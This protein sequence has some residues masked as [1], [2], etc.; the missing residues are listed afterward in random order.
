MATTQSNTVDAA[1]IAKFSEMADA[2]W[3]TA[4]PFRPLHQMN[5]CRLGYIR[6]QICAE[7]GRD[8]KALRSLA[9]LSVLDI[10][11]GGGLACEPLA[12]MGATV[13]GAD[14]SA[15]NIAVAKVHATEM[16]LDID[17]RAT[18]AEDLAAAGHQ[19][20][21]VLALEII[22][23]VADPKGFLSALSK[24]VRPGGLVI[25]S[26]L[27]RT[28]QSYALAILGAEYVMR[29]LPKGTHDWSKFITP[30]RMDEMLVE[31]GLDP[32]DR[33]GM[34]YDLLTGAWELSQATSVNY[35]TAAIRPSA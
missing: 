11:C 35:L 32:V 33:H 20:D 22:E 2:W 21:A 28:A 16:G 34:R 17:Y 9:G 10:G 13:T 26:T 7:T 3:D 8:S 18:T 23:H 19:F 14:A 5:P 30:D 1:E 29:L 25:V 15:E 4:G 27:N 6:D 24:L 12:R 31:A